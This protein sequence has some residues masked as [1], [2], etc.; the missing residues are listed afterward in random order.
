MKRCYD[1]GSGS[2]GDLTE[3]KEDLMNNTLYAIL[4]NGLEWS[5]LQYTHN[6]A[7]VSCKVIHYEKIR[8]AD[9][10]KSMQAIVNVTINLCSDLVFK[11]Y[12][13]ASTTQ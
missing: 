12:T 5:F 9:F 6:Y 11:E 4:T 13:L 2:T 10:F 7:T 8:L 1:L 3:L